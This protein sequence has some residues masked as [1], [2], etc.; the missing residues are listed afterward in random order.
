MRNQNRTNFKTTE[1][2]TKT[3][4]IGPKKPRLTPLQMEKRIEILEQQLENARQQYAVFNAATC[5]LL[6]EKFQGRAF[7]SI[8]VFLACQGWTVDVLPQ[9][10]L[11]NVRFTCLDADGNTQFVDPIAG[12]DDVKCELCD[13]KAV[14]AAGR[15]EAGNP[16]KPRCSAHLP[17]NAQV[18]EDPIEV[19]KPEEPEAEPCSGC[20]RKVGHN[21]D[22]PNYEE[23][24]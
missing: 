18:K 13:S 2:R 23:A 5:A 3:V 22:C 10:A 20:G 8:P 6:K 14:F 4:T 21:K 1:L 19:V 12:P 16:I 17:E 7:I 9:K 11:G 15:N 24:A